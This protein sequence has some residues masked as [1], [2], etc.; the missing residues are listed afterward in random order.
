M[1]NEMW[2]V[3]TYLAEEP[4]FTHRQQG[5]HQISH[6]PHPSRCHEALHM[7]RLQ[8]DLQLNKSK[9]Q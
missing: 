3:S 6:R 1:S 9:L 5:K 8:F 7:I 2:V 4:N